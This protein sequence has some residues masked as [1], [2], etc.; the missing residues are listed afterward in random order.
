MLLLDDLVD[1][2]VEHAERRRRRR[3]VTHH[4]REHA[5]RRAAANGASPTQPSADVA[6]SEQSRPSLPRSMGPSIGGKEHGRQRSVSTATASRSRP[7]QPAMVPRRRVSDA[8]SSRCPAPGGARG[9]AGA[10]YGGTPLSRYELGVPSI[11]LST[12][13]ASQTG[14]PSATP[15]RCDATKS[16]H[17]GRRGWPPR[18]EGGEA[19]HASGPRCRR[20]CHGGHGHADR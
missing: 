17:Q 19:A 3:V 5:W 7:R 16:V 1:A 12:C 4:P 13:S 2:D 14:T 18:H 20:G 8:V 6:N 15:Q 10:S 9:H 11:S